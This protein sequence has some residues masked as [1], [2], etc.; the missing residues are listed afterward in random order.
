MENLAPIPQ[1]NHNWENGAFLPFGKGGRG[2]G[3]G[4]MGVCCSILVCLRLWPTTFWVK[5][6]LL[7]GQFLEVP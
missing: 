6:Q 3:G 4:A 5:L 7:T 2:G 1:K